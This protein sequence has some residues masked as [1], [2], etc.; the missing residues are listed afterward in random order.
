MTTLVC[1][2]CGTRWKIVPE[3]A[4]DVAAV[5]SVCVTRGAT[6]T[7]ARQA[8]RDYGWAHGVPGI[9]CVD[10]WVPFGLDYAVLAER[11]CPGPRGCDS[12]GAGE[13]LTFSPAHDALFCACCA[14][15]ES[16]PGPAND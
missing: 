14:E 5:C 8:G 6:A 12:C 13:P 3:G 10:L 9:L 2:V 11:L 1:P 7:H 4:G 16:Q 15:R